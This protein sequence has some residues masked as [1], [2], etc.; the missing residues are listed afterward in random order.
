MGGAVMKTVIVSSRF[1][2]TIPKQ[3]RKRLGVEPGDKMQVFVYD[4]RIQLIPLSPIEEARGFLE[5][6]NSAIKREPNRN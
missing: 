1:Q 5:G 6:I 2:V 4:G 3:A